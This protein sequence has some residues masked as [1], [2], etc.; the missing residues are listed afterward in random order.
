MLVFEENTICI[1][2][3]ELRTKLKEIMKALKTSKVVLALRNK[4][5]AVL[6]PIERYQKME[7]LLEQHED[8]V[9]GYLAT[10]RDC[11]GAPAQDY[12][13]LD[14]AEAALKLR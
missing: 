3:S 5:F 10:E 12:V 8:Q 14:D 6:V 7:A 4:P 9:L 1:G 11:A 2:I 13:S